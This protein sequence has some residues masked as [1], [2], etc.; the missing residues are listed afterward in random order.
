MRQGRRTIVCLLIA[1]LLLALGPIARSFATLA[2]VSMLAGAPPPIAGCESLHGW[3]P[4]WA[5]NFIG[6]D[7]TISESYQCDGYRL[8][9]NIVQYLDQHQ[10]KEAVGELNEVIPRA[11]WNATTR[12]RQSIEPDVDVEEYRVEG[13]PL[14]ITIWNWYAVG[15]QPAASGTAVKAMEALNALTLR[16]RA[17]TNLTIAVE[18]EPGVDPRKALANDASEVWSWFIT[19]MRVRG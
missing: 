19:E 2:P 11:W 4:D 3:A 16:S 7:Y 9:L 1:L 8:H 5:P 17:T 15:T 12:R 13:T 6:S 10:G 18:P 14:R